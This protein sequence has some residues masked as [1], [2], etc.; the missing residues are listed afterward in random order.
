LSGLAANSANDIWA[1]GCHFAGNGSGQFRTLVLHWD[2]KSWKVVPSPNP[3]KDNFVG[4]ILFSGVV[5]SPG[6]VW[7]FGSEH[8]APNA[9]TLAIHTM[10]GN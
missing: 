3:T 4:D 5:P 2:G 7:I 8:E 6:N 10:T 1:F 9:E